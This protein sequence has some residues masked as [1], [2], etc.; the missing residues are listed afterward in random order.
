MRAYCA[1]G[2][3][4][5]KS[6]RRGTCLSASQTH[7]TV[8]STS[9]LTFPVC[10]HLSTNCT[11][12]TELDFEFQTVCHRT[13]QAEKHLARQQALVAMLA[14]KGQDTAEAEPS[15]TAATT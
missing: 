10:A 9:F 2:Q 7:K 15:L 11:D 3:L 1:N 14:A 13:H 5:S 4:P 6:P 8:R 12:M